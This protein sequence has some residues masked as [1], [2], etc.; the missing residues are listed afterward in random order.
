MRFE[1]RPSRGATPPDAA[2]VAALAI[3]VASIED[4]AAADPL[5][6]TPFSAWRAAGRGIDAFDAYDAARRERV[7]RR[8]GAR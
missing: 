6:V 8:G 1:I 4:A 5:P 7:L 3:A 2:V